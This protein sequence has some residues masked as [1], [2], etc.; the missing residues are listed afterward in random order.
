M[1][2]NLI[3]SKTKPK[4]TAWD[5]IAE[6]LSI[7]KTVGGIAESATSLFSKAP[8]TTGADAISRRATLGVDTDPV[9]KDM[10]LFSRAM[11]KRGY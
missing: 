9:T 1:A 6:G 5:T 8:P 3:E 7:A 10:T 2:L 11:R 4:K